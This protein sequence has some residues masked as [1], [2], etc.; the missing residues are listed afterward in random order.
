MVNKYQSA[1]GLSGNLVRGTLRTLQCLL[2]AVTAGLYGQDLA[3]A[4]SNGET[5]AS[6]WVYAEIV[7][8]LSIL[9]CL[10][11]TFGA[12]QKIWWVVCVGWDGVVC[13]L[14]VALFGVFGSI[15]LGD[16]KAEERDFA[17]SRGRMRA[18]VWVALVCAVL[19]AWIAVQGVG[20][21]CVAWRRA[22][23]ERKAR[24]MRQRRARDVEEGGRGVGGMMEAGT[25]SRGE[26]S[27]SEGPSCQ[28]ET[29]RPK[30]SSVEL[31]KSGLMGGTRNDFVAPPP[32]TYQAATQ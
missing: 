7:A 10:A 1:G 2:A 12:N 3:N 16:G 26:E 18:G 4:S 19:W 24:K 27:R 9:T 13:V 21:C 28:A 31:M 17:G 15:F 25:A 14:W 23:R 11:H 30:R 6:Q 22:W 5:A 29:A 8:G 20:W 32:P